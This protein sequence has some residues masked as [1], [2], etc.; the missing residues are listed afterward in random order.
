MDSKLKTMFTVEERCFALLTAV[1][2]D[3]NHP[4][5]TSGYENK[6]NT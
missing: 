6:R 3:I 2:H 5:T 1:A 4:G